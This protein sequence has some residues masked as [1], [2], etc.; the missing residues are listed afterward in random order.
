MLTLNPDTAPIFKLPGNADHF[1]LL[2]RLDDVPF[3]S[4][5]GVTQRRDGRWY[6]TVAGVDDVE[7]IRA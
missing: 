7:W 1:Y 5:L 2:R 3:P 6:K 4:V